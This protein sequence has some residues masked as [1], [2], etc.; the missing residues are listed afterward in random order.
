MAAL[1]ATGEREPR[2]EHDMKHGMRMVWI[3]GLLL[4]LMS[5]VVGAETIVIHELQVV[6]VEMI[7]PA[8][9]REVGSN[10]EARQE[11]L[12]KRGQ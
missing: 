9:Q 2:E 6:E 4:P 11:P 1:E 12:C 8:D 10:A 7:D 3:T 5:V